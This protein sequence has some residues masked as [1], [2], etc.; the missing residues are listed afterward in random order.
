[1]SLWKNA[2]K[3]TLATLRDILTHLC[4]SRKTISGNGNWDDIFIDWVPIERE[5]LESLDLRRP[6]L[7]PVQ[8]K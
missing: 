2:M 3:K 4:K 6:K 7:Y 8:L 1:M 5:E